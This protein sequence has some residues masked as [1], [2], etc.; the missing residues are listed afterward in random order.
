M[1]SDV[2]K[3]AQSG[4]V[5]LWRYSENPR[6]FR[7]WHLTADDAGVASI[8]SLL[9]LLARSD[10]AD[11]RT[12]SITPPTPRML[13]APN[14]QRGDAQTVSPLKWRLSHACAANTWSFPIGL[15]PASLT[16]G[17]AYVPELIQGLEGIPS[18]LGDYSIGN[19]DSATRLWFWW[20]L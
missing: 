4:T 9:K 17:D 13:Q 11:F 14:Y 18:G 16:V 10:P 20:L 2:T 6:A 7:G 1:Q 19:E 3:W 12:I 8:I 5:S 15:D